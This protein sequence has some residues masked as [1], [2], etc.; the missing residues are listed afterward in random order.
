MNT[1]RKK[2]LLYYGLASVLSLSILG[3]NEKTNKEVNALEISSNNLLSE[4][5]NSTTG[6]GNRTA[7]TLSGNAS[8]SSFGG[9]F[10]ETSQPNLES[11]INGN[12][13]TVNVLSTTPVLTA[14]SVPEFSASASASGSVADAVATLGGYQI[15]K[16]Y[17]A[18]MTVPIAFE[19]DVNDRGEV[20][21][22]L[23]GNIYYLGLEVYDDDTYFK[24]TQV[25]SSVP[26][27]NPIILCTYNSVSNPKELNVT[28]ENLKIATGTNGIRAYTPSDIPTNLTITGSNTITSSSASGHGIYGQDEIV[29]DGDGDLTVTSTGSGSSALYMDADLTMTADFIGKLTLESE[30]A[31]GK[32]LFMGTGNLTIDGGTLSATAKA[33]N[34]IAI[35]M[36][37]YEAEFV[38]NDGIL[39]ADGEYFGIG[40]AACKYLFTVNGGELNVTSKSFG[41]GGVETFILNDGIVNIE[42]GSLGLGSSSSN[43]APNL[44]F[45]GGEV[46]VVSTGN[47]GIG[48]YNSNSMGANVVITGGIINTHGAIAGIDVLTNN[49]KATKDQEL[50]LD[51]GVVTATS[52]SATAIIGPICAAAEIGTDFG[53]GVL[54]KNGIVDTSE[55]KDWNLILFDIQENQ[56]DPFTSLY[57]NMVNTLPYDAYSTIGSISTPSLVAEENRFYGQVYGNVALE[58]E[59]T[60][61]EGWTLDVPSGSSLRHDYLDGTVKKSYLTIAGELEGLTY[62]YNDFTTGHME[63]GVLRFQGVSGTLVGGEPTVVDPTDTSV[64]LLYGNTASLGG[65]YTAINGQGQ[66]QM[67]FSEDMVQQ[68]NRLGASQTRPNGDSQGTM[69]DRKIEFGETVGLIDVLEAGYGRMFYRISMNYSPSSAVNVGNYN[70]VVQ[71]MNH[72]TYIADNNFM[73]VGSVNGTFEI[74]AYDISGDEKISIEGTKYTDGNSSAIDALLE[75]ALN[76]GNLELDLAGNLTT[77]STEAIALKSYLGGSSTGTDMVYGTDY[78]ITVDDSGTTVSD[79][80]TGAVNLTFHGI[81]NY[82][83]TVTIQGVT[84][85]FSSTVSLTVDGVGDIEV[86]VNFGDVG[87]GDTSGRGTV[88]IKPDGTI[89]LDTIKV[90]YEKDGKIVNLLESN[91]TGIYFTAKLDD[92][93]P[94]SRQYLISI[95]SGVESVISFTIT[96]EE[97]GTG[98]SFQHGKLNLVTPFYQRPDGKLYPED[99]I[100]NTTARGDLTNGVDYE[101]Y[102]AN[103]DTSTNVETPWVKWNDSVTPTTGFNAFPVK[104]VDLKD[105]DNTHTDEE[106]IVYFTATWEETGENAGYNLANGIVNVYDSASALG[107]IYVAEGYGV[108]MS[109]GKL[110]LTARTYESYEDGNGE[111]HI[112]EVEHTLTSQDIHYVTTYQGFLDYVGNVGKNPTG[113]TELVAKDGDAGGYDSDNNSDDK[114]WNLTLKGDGLF[115]GEVTFEV[116]GDMLQFVQITDKLEGVLDDYLVLDFNYTFGSPVGIDD[117]GYLQDVSH[118][119]IYQ[120]PDGTIHEEDI[121][122]QHRLPSL[123]SSYQLLNPS[124][125]RTDYALVIDSTYTDQGS[126]TV[127]YKVNMTSLQTGKSLME[128]G[129]SA[130]TPIDLGLTVQK[131]G[132]GASLYRQGYIDLV[133][134]FEIEYVAPS[135]YI[136]SDEDGILET[137]YTTENQQE[138]LKHL[139]FKHDGAVIDPSKYTIIFQG[140]NYDSEDSTHTVIMTNNAVSG[141]SV[142]FNVNIT[143]KE[144]ESGKIVYDTQGGIAVSDSDELKLSEQLP[145]FAKVTSTREGYVFLGWTLDKDGL[146]AI[147]SDLSNFQSLLNAS[148]VVKDENN[149]VTLYAQWK[150]NDYTVT[151]DTQD[152]KV[153]DLQSDKMNDVVSF[154]SN[155]TREGYYFIGWSTVQS[156]TGDSDMIGEGKTFAELALVQDANDKWVYTGTIYAQWGELK[157]YNV[158]FDWNYNGHGVDFEIDNKGSKPDDTAVVSFPVDP[159]REG[160][161]F[162]GWTLDTA[163]T[164]GYLDT[165][166]T[167]FSHLSFETTAESPNKV[168]EM[169]YAQWEKVSYT[170]SFDVDGGE[171]TSGSASQQ[172]YW[173]DTVIPPTVEKVNYTFMGWKIGETGDYLKEN[174]TYHQLVANDTVS[175]VS[176]VA[177]WKKIE[178]TAAT[179]TL[180]GNGG[181]VTT[182][183]VNLG[184]DETLSFPK[185]SQFGTPTYTGYTFDGW[186]LTQN[187][188]ILTSTTVENLVKANGDSPNITLYAKWTKLE[189]TPVTMATIQFNA[190]GGSVS[191]SSKSL[192]YTVTLNFPKPSEFPTPTYSGYTFL[193]W[194]LVKNGALLDSTNY[195]TVEKLVKA[196]NNNSGVT[197]YAKWEKNPVVTPDPEPEPEPELLEYTVYYHPNMGSSSVVEERSITQGNAIDYPELVRS[198]YTFWG[199]YLE[200]TCNTLVNKDTV[201][202]DLAEN[203][204]SEEGI[205]L[206]ARWVRIVSDDDDDDDD[207]SSSSGGSS[208]GGSSSGG[209]S[210]GDSSSDDST[211]TTPD[212]EGSNTV[213]VETVPSISGSTASSTLTEVALEDILSTGNTVGSGFD[214]VWSPNTSS[215]SLDFTDKDMD[216]TL[217][218][219]HLELILSGGADS[220]T[221]K[222][223]G[224][225]VTF[226]RNAMEHILSYTI[227]EVTISA[228][229]VKSLSEEAQVAIGD[230]PLYNLGVFTDG[231]AVSSLGEGYAKVMIPYTP[232]T[233]EERTNI[234][235]GRVGFYGSLIYQPKSYFDGT[236]VQFIS[237]ELGTY[238]IVTRENTELFSDM[239]G[240]WAE[241]Y[242]SFTDS[243]RLYELASN[244]KADDSITRSMFVSIL[245]VL[246]NLDVTQ[247]GGSQ[248]TDVAVGTVESPYIQWAYENGIVAGKGDGIFDPNE[249]ITREEM[250]V[251]L[252]KY[253]AY[254]DV[255]LD[256]TE[257]NSSFVDDSE[258]SDWASHSVNY[259]QSVGLIHGKDDGFFDPIGE[260]TYGD[261]AVMIM[262]MV[263]SVVN[264]KTVFLGE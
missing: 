224:V 99:L 233:G 101:I 1:K 129:S 222:T 111:E 235:A 15:E 199:W 168:I 72:K 53:H 98:D 9:S 219:D 10:L 18:D 34:G 191:T 231:S 174:Q 165:A 11:G 114:V 17:D 184:L 225:I 238:G 262:R 107:T 158:Y 208:S 155:P 232:V 55:Q 102:H 250:A 182:N 159:T 244:L 143:M 166:N 229:L 95:Y 115:Q 256:T 56:T 124:L 240:H 234:L 164:S 161:K 60:I 14:S 100:L 67:V 54:I 169:V 179:F 171:I 196:N 242:L 193:G 62:S 149:A 43:V 170:V 131:A 29:L 23:S 52:D 64:P 147:P 176:L 144:E 172:L 85:K 117:K 3:N 66:I 150:S 40:H 151:F 80:G 221:V 25:D 243:R 82:T 194:T 205:T 96:A 26:N 157:Q 41:V 59:F 246:E 237:K 186:S 86:E 127:T 81:G 163:G 154:P 175:S 32:G 74:T 218:R 254:L 148:S 188:Q 160:Y 48:N 103:P 122:F 178:V 200:S 44:Y 120:K 207:D 39:N 146:V 185:P 228:D 63:F 197:L 136:D 78:Y 152:G 145:D 30:G 94:D 212:G 70:V 2:S 260:T 257:D 153:N 22:Y 162:L 195:G 133:D 223:D 61:E 217:S 263:E 125:S 38:L 239:M 58:Q 31:S 180:N 35:G 93:N 16:F 249:V 201:I 8:I 46:N 90:L 187:G 216:F 247:V 198:G 19:K 105:T 45:K 24:I 5:V 69:E 65:T 42:S 88:Y 20:F 79:G 91:D 189:E 181:T 28:I 37:S 245:G 116:T 130:Q 248:F 203:Y 50:C 57:P 108:V 141:D 128:L 192:A 137:W 109:V 118:D 106:K 84:V 264:S 6:S 236:Y 230:R 75:S 134:D 259:I 167:V 87:D 49:E 27:P 258:I 142:T 36:N 226:D 177:V 47:V 119:M 77:E 89:D 71:N 7:D 215:D 135:G 252:E 214:I 139:E 76:S 220:L 113:S 13:L 253:I 156:S 206:Y 190:N 227:K 51:G 92:S 12:D 112:R 211:V 210:S 204:N 110:G 121:T 33:S 140:N 21:S 126:D 241:E 83:K 261:H 138:I 202:D 255:E 251:M 97:A 4:K 73:A 173:L 183:H 68:T 213:F 132:T 209:S 123:N 104:V